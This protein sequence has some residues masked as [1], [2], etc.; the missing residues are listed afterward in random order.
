MEAGSF[1]FAWRS[2]RTLLCNG[3]CA[4]RF[5]VVF[6]TKINAAGNALVYSSRIGG[7]SSDEGFG[8]AVDSLGNAYLTGLTSSA[9][10]PRG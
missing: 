5:S 10:F 9:D 3:T 4:S 1:L 2:D 7:S 6:V 8:I